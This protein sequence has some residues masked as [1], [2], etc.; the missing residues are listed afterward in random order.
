MLIE[1]DAFFEVIAFHVFRGNICIIHTQ[2]SFIGFVENVVVVHDFLSLDDVFLIEM[3]DSV[4]SVFVSVNFPFENQMKEI[5]KQIHAS[6]SRSDGIIERS[7][8]IFA[9]F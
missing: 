5:D 7:V 1:I 2:T 3:L 9:E 6:R 8:G 4:G